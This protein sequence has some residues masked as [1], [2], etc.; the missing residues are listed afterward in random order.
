ALAEIASGSSGL[1]VET[2]PASVAL[3][4]RNADQA[5]GEAALKAALDGPGA[6]DGVFTKHGKMV[7]ELGVVSTNKG[8]ALRM[9]RRSAGATAAIFFGD[10][11]TDEDAFAILQG[12]DVAVKVGDGD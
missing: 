10:D 2:K 5:T 9:I 12:P 7:V 4:Y 3:H 11:V 8:D 6:L 1:S